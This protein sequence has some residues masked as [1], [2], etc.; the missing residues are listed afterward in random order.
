MGRLT[1]Q[2]VL[3]QACVVISCTCAV[4]GCVVPYARLP[5]A[6]C[7]ALLGFF[8]P[9]I[10]PMEEGGEALAKPLLYETT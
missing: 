5:V 4:T 8:N 2:R 1:G 3:Q 9:I 6:G 7:D 10:N